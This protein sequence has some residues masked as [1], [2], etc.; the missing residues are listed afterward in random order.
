MKTYCKDCECW[1]FDAAMTTE[2][3]GE[4]HFWPPGTDK[5]RF[6]RTKEDSF[7][8]QGIPKVV[9]NKKDEQLLTEG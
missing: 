1:W 3:E 2:F 4:C 5:A 7:C 8:F 6:P 9:P